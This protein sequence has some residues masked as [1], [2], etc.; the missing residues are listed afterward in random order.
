M[1]RRIISTRLKPDLFLVSLV[2]LWCSVAALAQS[3]GQSAN[4]PTPVSIRGTHLL[5]FENAKNNAN[6][7]L[8]IEGDALQFQKD[9]KPTEQVKIA[10]VQDIFL[11]EQ[12]KQVGGTPMTLGKA[13]VPFGGGRAISLFAH[14]KYDTLALEYVDSNGGMHGAI[15]QLNKGQAEALRNE[16]VAKGARVSESANEPVKQ[17]NAEVPSEGK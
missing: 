15:F 14:K 8:S 17:S 4:S 11:G 10:S 13:A 16:L 6:G 9:G 2:L 3:P 1:N 5:G 7:T 12:S